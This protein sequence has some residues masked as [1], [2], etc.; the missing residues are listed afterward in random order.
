MSSLPSQSTQSH[1]PANLV[2]ILEGSANIAFYTKAIQDHLT[3]NYGT[4]GQNILHLTTTTLT[5]PGQKPSYM[6][7]R[8]HPITQAPIP[9]SRKYA[10][11]AKTAAQDADATFDDLTLPLTAASEQKLDNDITTWQKT[12]SKF[13]SD[14]DKFR[15]L[16]DELLNFLRAHNSLAVTQ[17]LE[18]NALMPAFK[19]LPVTC[20]TRSQE[21]LAI[22]EDQFSKG[23]STVVIHELTKFLNLTQGPVAQEP[24]AAYFNRLT[25]QFLRIHPLLSTATTVEELLQM[26][27]CMVCIKGLN[28]SHP[29]TLRAL[30]E[31]LQKFPATSLSHF[32]E[33]R[34]ST[35]AAQYSDISTLDV[36]ADAVAEQSSAFIS[37]PHLKPATTSTI[38]APTPTPKTKGLQHL[39]RTD[40]CAYCLATFRKYFYHSESDCNFKKRGITPTTPRMKTLPSRSL[41][42][43]IAALE[44]PLVPTT[45]APSQQQTL[46]ADQIVTYLA[47]HGWYPDL[48][49]PNDT[50][51][52]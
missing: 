21:Y 15:K 48:S 29:P 17:I 42:A 18:A 36:E 37:V 32:P 30:L 27:L 35:L 51:S 1:T 24:T 46:T 4:I 43:R 3:S 49:A 22:I 9:L 41:A 2:P 12:S 39:G 13:D 26:L 14:L 45:I 31:H 44:S 34:A 38:Q 11:I 28:R 33:L 20:I 5:P 10:Q 52:T 19:L 16:D 47:S 8:L 7:P 6:D 25:N 40:H 50:T 23:N